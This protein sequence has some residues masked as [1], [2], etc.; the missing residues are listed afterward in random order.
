MPGHYSVS[1]KGA[2]TVMKVVVQ[3]T[4]QQP[5]DR[6]CMVAIV[7]VLERLQG[8]K[9]MV[10]IVDVLERLQGLKEMAVSVGL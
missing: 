6:P 9:D 7:D 3:C 1:V 5:R 8:L 4:V 2:C 10:A